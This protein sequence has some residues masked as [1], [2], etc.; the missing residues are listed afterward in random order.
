MTRSK[1]ISILSILTGLFAAASAAAG[2]LLTG[3]GS[4]PF[5]FTTLHGSVSEI[6]GRGVYA[7][8]PAFKVPIFRG[9][10]AVM[11]L[12]MLP[13]LIYALSLY[14][15]GGLRGRVLLPAVLVIFLYNAA[16]NALG[17]TYNNLV[18]LYIVYFSASL[19]AFILAF[20]AVDQRAV[21]N[22][23]GARFPE[24]GTAIFLFVAGS[25]VLIWLADIIGGLLAGG[26]PETLG[27]YTTEVT[28]VFDLAIILPAA[29]AAGVLLLRRKPLGYLLAA[30][31]LV[32]NA[33]I[34]MIVTGQTVMQTL[35]GIV[36]SPGQYIGYMGTFVVMGIAAIFFITRLLGSL[37][38]A[39]ERARKR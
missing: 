37:P 20:S 10:D 25:S 18:L 1:L 8:N 33:A 7:L 4:G 28:Y 27:P 17:V 9:T 23:I 3:G 22:S 39:A 16:T 38:A 13:A 12:I 21:A 34:A 26:A 5:D 14:R 24:R 31:I 29:Y 30:V 11:L 6:Y 36:L 32:L 15:R 35:A 19:F 2:L